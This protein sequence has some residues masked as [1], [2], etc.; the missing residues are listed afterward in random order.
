M[1]DDEPIYV[2]SA[3]D[4][5]SERLTAALA[6]VDVPAIGQALRH[7]Y[8]IVPLI[9]TADGETQNRVYRTKEPEG[10]KA[11]DFGIFSSTEALSAFLGPDQSRLFEIVKGSELRDFLRTQQGAIKLVLFDPA[12]PHPVSATVEDVIWSLE[13]RLLDDDVAW[14][15]A[16]PGSGASA[17]AAGDRAIAIDT[18][19]SRDWAVVDVTDADTRRQ[20]VRE[21]LDTQLGGFLNRKLRA[22]FEAW[23]ARAS[24][25]A[26][27]AGGRFLAFLIRRSDKAAA[28]VNLAL[29]WHELGPAIGDASHLERLTERLRAELA[30]GDELVGAETPAGPF[31]R[32]TRVRG[33]AAELEA[34]DRPLLIVDYWLGFPDGRGLAQYSFSSPHVDQ[35]DALLVLFDNIVVRSRWVMDQGE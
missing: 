13:P 21:L 6:A 7:D 4:V 28:A 35:R 3:P 15:T 22:D 26:L 31:V 10:G 2:E 9:T 27:G 12:G 14:A 19:L 30:E 8:V 11:F 20:Q 16:E 1:P 17:V 33:A 32:N 5:G 23:F 24:E 25:L 18:A 34:S 29:Y